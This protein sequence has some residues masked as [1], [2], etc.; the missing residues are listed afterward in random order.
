MVRAD[1]ADAEVDDMMTRIYGDD[2]HEVQRVKPAGN[3]SEEIATLRRDRAELDDL[4]DDYDQRHAALTGEIR[5]LVADDRDNPNQPTVEWVQSGVTI[6]QHW[7]TLGTAG[8]RDWL[9]EHGWLF[10]AYKRMGRWFIE[11]L[12]RGMRGGM[13]LDGQPMTDRETIAMAVSVFMELHPDIPA[14]V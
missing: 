3:H 10:I 12:T 6:A 11:P 2:P 7:R 5:R 9:K 1:F 13:M 14:T 8:R 4:A